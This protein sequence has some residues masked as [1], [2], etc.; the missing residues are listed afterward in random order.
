[1][2]DSRDPLAAIPAPNAPASPV[3]T[4]GPEAAD[5]STSQALSEALRSS[6]L[7]VKILMLL[8]VGYFLFSGVFTVGPQEKA[9]ILR[10][11]KPLGVGEGALLG[12]GLHFAFP[13]P[14]DE[15]VRIPIG[16][17][18][19][20]SSSIGWYATTAAREAAKDEPPPGPSLNPASDSYVLTADGNILHVRGNLRYRISEPGL[21]YAFDFAQATKL[22]Q[23]AF[24]S[25]ILYA[26]AR[27]TVDNILTADQ[28][29]YQELVRQRLEQLIDQQQLSIIID[30]IDLK[31]IP[32]R[33]L[34][35][36]FVAVLEASIQSTKAL[37]DAR[38]YANQTLSRAKAEQNARINASQTERGRLVDFVAAEAK[39]FTD[40]LPGYRSNPALFVQQQQT[41]VLKRVMNNVQD[42]WVLPKESNGKAPEL[43]L[44]LNREPPKPK[45]VAAPQ[46]DGHGH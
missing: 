30:Q 14:I 3:P 32:P 27:Y 1:M 21:R 41:E 33:Q 22:V 12:P 11:G 42:K 46:G 28:T 23:N 34:T 29:G 17:V 15:I 10:F 26:T 20:V 37:N 7:I 4:S 45:P 16:Q 39:R 44:Q 40:L 5:D 38:Q 35:A 36:N 43:R 25:A 9:V 2:N 6:F 31:P 24:N 8:V 18:Q 13:E 19:T